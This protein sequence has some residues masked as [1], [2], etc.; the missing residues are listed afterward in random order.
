[1]KQDYGKF[2]EAISQNMKKFHVK[3]KTTETEMNLAFFIGSLTASANS[4]S[5]SS[6]SDNFGELSWLLL[7]RDGSNFTQDPEMNNNSLYG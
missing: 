5:I 1:M 4:V 7:F 6:S 3:I 2:K